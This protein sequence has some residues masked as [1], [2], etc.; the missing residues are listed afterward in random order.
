[1]KK[2]L[3]ILLILQIFCIAS[4]AQ[5]STATLDETLSWLKQ[6]TVESTVPSFNPGGE[7]TLRNKSALFEGCF[8]SLTSVLTYKG[9]NVFRSEVSLSDLD[10][11]SIVVKSDRVASSGYKDPVWTVE[12]WVKNKARL[13]KSVDEKFAAYPELQ[14]HYNSIAIT[15]FAVKEMANRYSKALSHAIKLCKQKEPF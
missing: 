4:F 14:D 15:G 11:T 3:P 9:D 12:T 7:M 8:M 13:V 10:E 2:L 6:K 5:E 1:M